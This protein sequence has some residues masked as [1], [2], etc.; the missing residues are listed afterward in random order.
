MREMNR[1]KQALTVEE[2]SAVL[3]RCTNG[4]MAVMGPDGYPYGVPL[5]YVYHNGKIYFHCAKRGY[6]LECL[7]ESPKV[8]FTV[9]DADEI[10]P[11]E[12]TTYFRSVIIQGQARL[13]EDGEERTNG[14]MAL[15]EKYSGVMPEEMKRK[16]VAECKGSLI[17]A[18][19]ID[20][21]TGK[22]ARELMERKNRAASDK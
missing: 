21:M 15:V 12:Y 4:I 10:V 9:V 13:V 18:I 2:C 6:K 11:E 16:E 7:A 8:S 20:G 22:E 14:F 1:K 19:D 3:E 17:Y 5:S